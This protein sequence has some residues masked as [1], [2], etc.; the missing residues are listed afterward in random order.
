MTDELA[1]GLL[2]EFP[3]DIAWKLSQQVLYYDLSQR[4]RP[5]GQIISF[6]PGFTGCN[7]D[8][9]A[10]G[11]VWDPVELWKSACQPGGYYLLNS[12]CGYPP[13]AEIE[14]PIFV[15][16][17][18]AGTIIWELDGEALQWA[19]EDI[20]RKRGF[21]RLVFRRADYEAAIRGMVDAAKAANVPELPV[22]ELKPNCSKGEAYETLMALD[23]TTSI[24]P[25]PVLPDS[26][27]L[28]FGFKGSELCFVDGQAYPHWPERLFT[29]W[30]VHAAFKRWAAFVS[31]G[32]ALQC[33]PDEVASGEIDILTIMQDERRNDFFLKSSAQR[34]ACDKAG[35]HLAACLRSAFAEGASAPDV[36]VRYR[37]CLLRAAFK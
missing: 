37:P 23:F 4:A 19:L 22:E 31:R 11:I 26:T 29:R 13:D 6:A 9:E 34:E 28:E 21:L 7:P 8:I 1:D 25:E 20:W 32:Y 15:S 36:E 14:T 12:D 5:T 27:I 30:E 16:H 17:P 3:S 2:A 18:D 24:S 33:Y 10:H 35:K